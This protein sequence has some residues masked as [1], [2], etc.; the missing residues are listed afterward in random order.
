MNTNRRVNL[1]PINDISNKDNKYF[2]S[3]HYLF[4]WT[5]KISSDQIFNSIHDSNSSTVKN[6]IKEKKFIF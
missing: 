4:R 6:K 2:G 3:K 1:K 5:K